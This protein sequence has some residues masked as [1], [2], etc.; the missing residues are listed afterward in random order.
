M[1][2]LML[3]TCE[4]NASG[5]DEV[6][7]YPGRSVWGVVAVSGSRHLPVSSWLIQLP[8]AMILVGTA[9]HCGTALHWLIF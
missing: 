4:L 6:R 2:T 1:V 3:R 8:N 5:L 9:L 7:K